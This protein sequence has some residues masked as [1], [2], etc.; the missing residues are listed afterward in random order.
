LDPGSQ[1]RAATAR[2]ASGGSDVRSSTVSFFFCWARTDDAVSSDSRMAR[3]R[4]LR[5]DEIKVFPPQ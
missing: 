1:V 3:R 4:F 5:G 2:P